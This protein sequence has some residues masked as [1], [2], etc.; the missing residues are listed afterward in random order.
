MRIIT[1]SAVAVLVL[2]LIAASK[3]AHAEVY[4]DRGGK[5]VVEVERAPA[6]GDWKLEKEI[7]GYSGEGYYV[8]RGAQSLGSPPGNE[9]TYDI[10]LCEKGQYWFKFRNVVTFHDNKEHNDYFVTIDDNPFRKCMS[11]IQNNWNWY[12]VFDPCWCSGDFNLDAGL[13]KVRIQ[14]RSSDFPIDKFIVYKAW[15]EIGYDGETSDPVHA[16]S[17]TTQDCNASSAR[18]NRTPS[19]A[20]ASVVKSRE[21]V[22]VHSL[23]GRRLDL[24]VL[25]TA[26][27]SRK[28]GMVLVRYADGRVDR[29]LI[30]R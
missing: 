23:D 1:I 10:Y 5:V 26:S 11:H 16:E 8:W 4:Y 21:I 14:P 24:S 30:R 12:T 29:R 2:L 22:S 13:H 19:A 28:P 17:P 27:T 3:L 7:A 6:V 18:L 25:N 9:L 15:M 20:E